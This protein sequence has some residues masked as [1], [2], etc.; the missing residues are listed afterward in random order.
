MR[1]NTFREILK[2]SDAERYSRIFR[3]LDDEETFMFYFFR[4]TEVSEPMEA[5]P[6][7]ELDSI[8]SPAERRM[9]VFGGGKMAIA[10]V[11]GIVKKGSS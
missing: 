8:C 9:L 6:I 4:M 7:S 1:F 2:K 3:R 10:L 5:A 11:D